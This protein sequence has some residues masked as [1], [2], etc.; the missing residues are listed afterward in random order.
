MLEDKHPS[1]VLRD[2]EEIFA[3]SYLL[4]R[5]TVP[6]LE[7]AKMRGFLSLTEEI[8]AVIREEVREYEK[9]YID[10]LGVQF[11]P[12]L[13]T[14]W[15]KYRNTDIYSLLGTLP[16]AMNARRRETL[17]KLAESLIP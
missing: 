17:G 9:P 10:A 14:L 6:A 13:R 7:D 5:E 8:D 16:E 15:R 11:R 1:A 4:M 3:D 2:L 12:A